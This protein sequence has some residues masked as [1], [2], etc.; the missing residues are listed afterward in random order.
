MAQD[1]QTPLHLA[2]QEGHEAAIK[3]LM[4]AKADVHAKDKVSVCG[5][6][7]GR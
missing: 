1:G 5:G 2:A 7:L 3:A 6:V 4:A